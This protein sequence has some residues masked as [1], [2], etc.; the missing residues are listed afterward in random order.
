MSLSSTALRTKSRIPS[1]VPGLLATGKGWAATPREYKTPLAEAKALF[2][3]SRANGTG[4]AKKAARP[5][6]LNDYDYK[7]GG[8]FTFLEKE[9]LKHYQDLTVRHVDKFVSMVQADTEYSPATKNGFFR[10]LRALFHWAGKDTEAAE[11]GMPAFLNRLP[12]IPAN[13]RREWIPSPQEMA[14]FRDSF[15]RSLIWGLRDYTVITLILNTG[16]RIGGICDLKLEDI[17]LQQGFITV[18]PKGGK[19][20]YPVAIDVEKIGATL[21]KW[22]LVR[23]RY[24]R[25]EYAF[26]NKYG[27]QATPHMFQQS[28]QEQR[29]RSGLGISGENVI[30]PHVVRHF[31]CTYY[32]VNGGTLHQLQRI[33]GHEDLSTLMIYV[34]LAN[35]LG[36]TAEESNR[37][38]PLRHLPEANITNPNNKPKKSRKVR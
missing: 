11:M 24:A 18:H 4:G 14:N 5:A 26:I 35:Q 9:G 13:P 34:H 8:F 15:D 38:N 36:A 23:E 20:S 29:E 33:T 2:L 1:Y 30:T 27:G 31:F 12:V 22:L 7:A 32:L 3:Q 21:R 6:T 37:V 10:A 28:F 25:C 19:P 16:I 17:N